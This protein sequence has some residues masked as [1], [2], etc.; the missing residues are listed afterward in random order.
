MIN[1]SDSKKYWEPNE[2]YFLI[3]FKAVPGA[4]KKGPGERAI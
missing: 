3:S 1:Q 4:D 2:V